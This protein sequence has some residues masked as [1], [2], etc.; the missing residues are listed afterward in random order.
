MSRIYWF[1]L[2]KPAIEVESYTK[3]FKKF[4]ATKDMKFS[5]G[6][7]VIHGFIGPNGAGKTT[8][9]KALIG[10]YLPTRG[11]IFING[12]KAGSVAANS[13]IGYIPERASFPSHLNCLQY[14]ATM[15]ELSGLSFKKAKENAKKILNDLG[16]IKHAKRR[17]ISFSSG[18]QKKILL[19]QALIT[20]PSILI[21]DE[22]AAN[23][24]PTARKDLFD[25]LIRL[26]N[27]GKTIFISSHILAE[28]ERLIDE[29]TFVYY[30][31]IIFSG[32]TSEFSS[33]LND[34]Y[35][36]SSDNEKIIKVFSENERMHI[37]GDIKTEIIFKS[38]SLEERNDLLVLLGELDV[39]IKS[40][41]ANDLQA[42]YD[43]L[44]SEA[45]KHRLG[46]QSLND[47]KIIAMNRQSDN[48]PKTLDHKEERKE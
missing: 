29:V 45:E 48:T 7:G 16:L 10:A 40:F 37:T 25:Q 30:G 4:V 36:K 47:E 13:L 26:R 23:L 31:E 6:H 24:D 18:M 12:H 46:K 27:E 8:A 35:V 5:V 28:L 19:A 2:S 43:R 41:R 20:N 39:E 3:R 1:N 38:L 21:L 11:K 17:P 44:I 33:K 9:I 22:P 14:L 32:K 15:G 42:I 34:V